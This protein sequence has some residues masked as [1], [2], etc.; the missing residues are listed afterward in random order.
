[1]IQNKEKN[2]LKKEPS[3]E[4]V[5]AISEIL[6]KK[7]FKATTMDLVANSLGMSKRT[8]YEMFDNKDEMLMSAL[9]YLHDRHNEEMKEIFLASGNVME[10]LFNICE[11]HRKAINEL[12]IEFFRDMDS[13]FKAHRE[14]YVER[15]RMSNRGILKVFRLGIRQGVFRS[16]VNYSIQLRIFKV[17]ME[18]LKRMEEVFSNEF[19]CDEVLRTISIGFLRSIASPKGMIVLDNLWNDRKQKQNELSEEKQ[20]Q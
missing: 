6:V 5:K 1:M 2:S 19:T 14:K 11:H 3:P 12:S 4:L 18:S 10:A 7:G 16:D 17:Q 8:L 20:K 9:N 15:D 13:R